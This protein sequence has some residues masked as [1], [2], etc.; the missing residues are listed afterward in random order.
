MTDA[1]PRAVLLDRDGVINEDRPRSVR[2][3]HEFVLLPDVAEAIASL[4]HHGYLVFVIT[5][6][7]VVGRGELA[8]EDLE[9]IHDRMKE[10]IR[11]AGG[12]IEAVYVCPHTDQ[13][14][15]VCRKPQ[16]ELL[17][18]AQ[19]AHGFDL[20]T[21]WFVGDDLR[22]IQAA[23]AA[24]CRPALVRT[25]KGSRYAGT[26]GLPVLEDLSQFVGLLC[27]GALDN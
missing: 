15:C 24:G 18:E 1:F 23:E 6:Q 20:A 14:G 16:P 11:Q 7:A 2:S 25:G 12:R 5:N 13:D 22:D 4:T 26:A 21:T 19:R 8:L 9:A 3:V 27:S 17:F 10:L